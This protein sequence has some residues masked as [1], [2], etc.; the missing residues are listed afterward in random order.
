MS[1]ESRYIIHPAALHAAMQL[2]IVAAHAGTATKFK[3]AYMPV[4]FE[5]IK[6]WPQIAK[7]TIDSARSIAKGTLKG[8]RGLAADLILVGEGRKPMLEAKNLLLIASEQNARTLSEK[9]GPYTRIV[10][11]PEFDSLSDAA[12]AQLFPPVT[13]D[14]DAIIPSLNSL[15][16][17]HLAQ[18]RATSPRTF[19]EG[20]RV[21]VFDFS[22][23]FP[24]SVGFPIPIRTRSKGKDYAHTL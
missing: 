24:P 4:A 17:H 19:E 13:L 14:D 23:S 7:A 11:K 20:S 5:S 1:G 3:R 6:V 15:A 10:W 21:R 9:N 12:V 22:R 2:S 16:L 8:V 18:F